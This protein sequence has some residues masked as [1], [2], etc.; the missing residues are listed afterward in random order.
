MQSEGWCIGSA[1]T[2]G[3][4]T[5]NIT[6]GGKMYGVWWGTSIHATGRVN[7]SSGGVMQILGWADFVIDDGGVIDI[8]GPTSLLLL[9]TDRLSLVNALITAGRIT[10]NGV[11]GNVIATYNEQIAGYTVVTFHPAQQQAMSLRR[12]VVLDR[13]FHQIP[14]E[15]ACVIHSADVTLVKD[16]G[17]DFAKV[18]INP[19]LM[20]NAADGTINTA[21]IW[22][23]D[24]VVN[25]FV[26]QGVPVVV[27][28]H[29]ENIFKQTYLGTEIGFAKLLVFYH[30]FAAYLAARWGRGEVAFELMT[31]P[32][33]N[34]QSW[35]TMLPQMWNAAR[36]AMPDNIIILDADGSADIGHLILLNPVADA[37]VYYSFT[38]YDPFIFDL[39][40]AVWMAPSYLAGLQRVPYPSSP[41][42]I[43]A[44][45]SRILDYL[46]YTGFGDPSAAA[47]L[48]AYGNANWNKSKMQ[49]LLA[50]ITAWNNAHGG[51]LKIFCAEFGVL[52]ANQSQRDT[53]YD[54]GC[55]E[56]DR[57]QFIKDRRESLEES[58]ISW[59]YWSLNETFTVLKPAVRQPFA[60]D[61]TTSWA[62]ND[63]QTAL[64][65]PLCGCGCSVQ[66]SSPYDLDKDCYVNFDDFAMFAGSWFECSEPTDSNC[67]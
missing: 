30:D 52:D 3:S 65:L 32:H 23:I 47:D 38:T 16:L 28:I 66:P 7:I 57:I 21:N 33:D 49:A 20:M 41:A 25:K 5:V 43:A 11:V 59:A 51:N 56:A 18:I 14:V 46:N 6:N 62:D 15:A 27:C 19:A 26:S 63:T 24:E 36:T 42:I 22:Y 44:Q 61:A 4:G 35:N 8:S 12:G 50:P 39:Q 60:A 17:F 40:G 37:S 9:E 29:P 53:G 48:T 31:E 1:A 10:G 45:Q 64:G 34:Y 55:A 2:F 13:Q 67:L 54:T 58:N